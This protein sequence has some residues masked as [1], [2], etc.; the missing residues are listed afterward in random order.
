MRVEKQV[1]PENVLEYVSHLLHPFGRGITTK[2]HGLD[3]VVKDFPTCW[4]IALHRCERQE[5]LDRFEDF[6]T[7]SSFGG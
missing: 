2:G 5:F 7:V 1:P 3:I 4:R 6:F